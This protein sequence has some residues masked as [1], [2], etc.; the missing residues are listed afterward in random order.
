M[1][2]VQDLEF[3]L[4]EAHK[5]GPS[6][7]PVQILLWNL[8]ALQQINTPTQLVTCKLTEGALGP[9]IPIVSKDIKE[10]WPQYHAFRNTIC[11]TESIRDL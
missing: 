4:I 1:T 8:P 6:I 10:D 5:I 7:Q 11:L 2:Q 3:H 9:L